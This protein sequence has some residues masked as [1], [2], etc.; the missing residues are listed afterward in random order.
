[1]VRYFAEIH[2]RMLRRTLDVGYVTGSGTEMCP[3][4]ASLALSTHIDSQQDYPGLW[5]EA[6]QLQL[7]PPSR[8]MVST[9]TQSV[10]PTPGTASTAG[11]DH[12]VRP[13]TRHRDMT[14]P[15]G[16]Q[17]ITPIAEP[18]SGLDDVSP[19]QEDGEVQQ[20]KTF[21][22][23]TGRQPPGGACSGCAEAGKKCDGVTG[24]GVA[25]E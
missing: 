18:S 17:N 5:A 3:L 20:A 9:G 6:L 19:R 15:R 25:C 2:S 16:Y 8:A 11:A 14:A 21:P 1:M 22:S 4:S 23:F 7:I 24:S 13:N 12:A 10:S